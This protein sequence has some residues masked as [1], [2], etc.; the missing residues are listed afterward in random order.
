MVEHRL[1]A[2]AAWVQYP[3]M[4]FYFFLVVNSPPHG[5][6]WQDGVRI[7]TTLCTA[8]S[9]TPLEDFEEVSENNEKG[10]MLISFLQAAVTSTNTLF[11]LKNRHLYVGRIVA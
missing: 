8:L 6:P 9:R 11:L 7:H 10:G 5:P 2:R 1:T 3:D 4:A